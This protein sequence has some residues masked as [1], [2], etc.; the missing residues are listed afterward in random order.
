MGMKS[1]TPHVVQC[2]VCS[3]SRRNFRNLTVRMKFQRLER[4]ISP[5]MWGWLV[6]AK[7]GRDVRLGVIAFR[8]DERAAVKAGRKRHHL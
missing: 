1:G 2:W 7:K 4:S 6:D 3:V 5:R 8:R